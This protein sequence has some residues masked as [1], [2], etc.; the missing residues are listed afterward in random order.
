MIYEY[1]KFNCIIPVINEIKVVWA[2]KIIPMDRGCF[3]NKNIADVIIIKIKINE[4]SEDSLNKI[5]ILEI[6]DKSFFPLMF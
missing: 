6:N 3:I 5:L 2:N 1:Q 4:I